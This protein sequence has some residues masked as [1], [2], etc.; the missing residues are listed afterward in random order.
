MFI[1][2]ELDRLNLIVYLKLPE[3]KNIIKGIKLELRHESLKLSKPL[4]W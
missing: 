1:M 2:W 4:I 3:R